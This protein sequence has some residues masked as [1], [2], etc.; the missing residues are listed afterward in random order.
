MILKNLL[1]FSKLID[2]KRIVIFI[3]SAI[4][5]GVTAYLV[6]TNVSLG[7]IDTTE[8]E[9]AEVEIGSVIRTIPAEGS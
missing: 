4:V 1:Y 8:F 5:I 3:V 2:V 7:G 9:I 6:L